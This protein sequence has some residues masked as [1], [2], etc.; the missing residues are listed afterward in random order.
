MHFSKCFCKTLVTNTQ[1]AKTGIAPPW[2]RKLL[3]DSQISP[4][5]HKWIKQMTDMYL[6]FDWIYSIDSDGD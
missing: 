6:L 3:T 1:R 5:W 2:E 4:S